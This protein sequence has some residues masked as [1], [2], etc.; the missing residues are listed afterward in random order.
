[1]IEGQVV[2]P[3]RVNT[4]FGEV[5]L[6][7]SGLR[8]GRVDLLVRP[9]NVIH[10]DAGVCAAHVVSQQFQGAYTLTTLRLTDG[11]ILASVDEKLSTMALG[12]TVM[13]ALDP[14]HLRVFTA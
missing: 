1:M 14:K 4:L 12:S 5:T 13:L 3:E 11:T 10:A 7:G 2:G 8:S 9:W 6:P